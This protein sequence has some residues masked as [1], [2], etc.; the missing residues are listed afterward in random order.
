MHRSKVNSTGKLYLRFIRGAG[1]LVFL[2]L[3]LAL[4]IFLMNACP[5][6]A[7]APVVGDLDGDN[8]KT[9]LDITLLV[10][11]LNG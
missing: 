3:P 6:F 10:N 7:T 1:V 8:Q 9:I 5:L 2:Q 4:T 11:H